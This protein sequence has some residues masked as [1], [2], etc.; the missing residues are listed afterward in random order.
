VLSTPNAFLA[1]TTDDITSAVTA[2]PEPE[3]WGLMLAGLG[4]LAALA[5]RRRR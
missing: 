1:F 3:T 5:R 2:V 4:T